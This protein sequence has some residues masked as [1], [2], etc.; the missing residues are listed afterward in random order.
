MGTFGSARAKDITV[1]S[2]TVN[3]AFR[4][5]DLAGKLEPNILI[6]ATTARL[7]PIP[8]RHAAGARAASRT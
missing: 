5:N 2:D 6:G 3:V 1:F 4:L 7:I 8:G